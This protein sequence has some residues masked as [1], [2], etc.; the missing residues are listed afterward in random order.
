M[1][2]EGTMQ[3]IGIL[4]GTMA[5]SA[6]LLVTVGIT[7]DM[8]ILIVGTG[9]GLLAAS[10]PTL[11]FSSHV[12]KSGSIMITY[13][14]LK[15]FLSVVFHLFSSRC[16]KALCFLEQFALLARCTGCMQPG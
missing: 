7:V 6:L 12:K 13:A 5:V 15:A 4:F 3:K 16:T 1:S 8:N 10:S 14:V 2:Y 11:F 9:V